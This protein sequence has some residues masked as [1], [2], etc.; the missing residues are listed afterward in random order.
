MNHLVLLLALLSIGGVSTYA[1]GVPEIRREQPF[2][3][4]KFAA[5]N[6]LSVAYRENLYQEIPELLKNL[7]FGNSSVVPNSFNT[8]ITGCSEGSYFSYKRDLRKDLEIH[9]F[10]KHFFL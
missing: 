7:H 10:P 9:L 1:S 5:A 3:T 6:P 8:E 2:S 4:E